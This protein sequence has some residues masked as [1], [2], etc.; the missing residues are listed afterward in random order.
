M[1]ELKMFK[2]VCGDVVVCPEPEEYTNTFYEE[3]EFKRPLQLFMGPG[4]DGKIQMA[5]IPWMSQE[6]KVKKIGIIASANAP[7]PVEQEYI[8]LTT[9]IQLVSR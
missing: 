8:K 1:I 5:L 2:L 6:T 7:H 3:V 4:P 9:N